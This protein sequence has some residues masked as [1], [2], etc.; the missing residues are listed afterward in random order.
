MNDVKRWLQRFSYMDIDKDGYITSD[1]ICHYLSI[2]SDA[3][4]QA[5]FTALCKV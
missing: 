3:C 4:T 2:P 5:V 1:D